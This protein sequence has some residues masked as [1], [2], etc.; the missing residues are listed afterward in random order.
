MEIWRF[1]PVPAESGEIVPLLSKEGAGVVAEVLQRQTPPN[2]PLER[3]EIIQQ[4][5]FYFL[6]GRESLLEKI[7]EFDYLAKKKFKIAK[8]AARLLHFIPSI[9]MIAVCNNFYYRPQSDIDFFIITQK[10]RLWFTRFCAIIILEIFQ[11]RARGKQ[12][13]DRVCLSFYLSEEN[14]H[15]ENIALKPE[16][17][18]LSYWLAFLEPIY[19]QDCY[20]K[21][22]RANSWIEKIFPNI[23]LKR[24]VALR[25][26]TDNNFS[27]AIRKIKSFFCYGQWG[28]QLEKFL[29]KIQWL[30]ISPHL[31]EMAKL[32]DNRVVINDQ[33]LKF[34]E[35]D[36]REEFVKQL[37][38]KK[39]ELV[40]K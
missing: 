13:A 31:K 14:L 39:E 19:G 36:R 3:G 25:Q 29:Q 11:L 15:L 18:Y 22:W 16:D 33:M 17:P 40:I 38:I 9:K 7:R 6:S 21:F 24:P 26:V 5:G 35:N 20:E 4:N 28:D 12:T 23:L 27:L 30:K 8:H 32:N 1:L 34:H 10:N 37:R 2:L